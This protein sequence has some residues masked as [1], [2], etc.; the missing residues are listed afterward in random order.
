[1]LGPGDTTTRVREKRIA[2]KKTYFL[3]IKPSF[4]HD[5]VSK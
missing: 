5:V 1:M 3:F 4:I 2:I